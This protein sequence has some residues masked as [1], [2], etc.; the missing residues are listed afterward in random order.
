MVTKI[1]MRATLVQMK[2]GEAVEIPLKS[3]AHN[4]IRNCACALGVTYPGRKY[5]VSLNREAQNCK[6]T[7]LS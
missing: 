5:S 2:P 4:S 1:S 6:V 7:R 3:F